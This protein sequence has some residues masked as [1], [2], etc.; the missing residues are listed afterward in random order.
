MPNS[1]TAPYVPPKICDSAQLLLPIIFTIRSGLSKKKKPNDIP[2]INMKNLSQNDKS[3][4]YSVYQAAGKSAKNN[5]RAKKLPNLF[6][7]AGSI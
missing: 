1:L 4:M 3:S 6:F 5:W 7:L 2:I